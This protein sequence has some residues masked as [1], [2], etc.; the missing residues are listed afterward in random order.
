MTTT[1]P[2]GA[3]LDAFCRQHGIVAD[4]Q[5]DGTLTV[6]GDALDLLADEYAAPV[7]EVRPGI[8]RASIPVAGEPVTF[9]AGGV[10]HD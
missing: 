7:T 8:F 2:T 9:E 10:L 5:L 4:V 1:R 3:D 6:T